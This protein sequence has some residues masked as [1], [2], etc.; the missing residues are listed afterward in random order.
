MCLECCSRR[1]RSGCGWQYPR[2][3]GR[4]GETPSRTSYS[5]SARSIT[6]RSVISPRTTLTFSSSPFRTSSHCGTQSRTRQTT[7]AP[8]SSRLRVS[9][10]PSRPVAP[11]TKTERSRQKLFAI[12]I[13]SR[14]PGPRSR[15]DSDTST[16]GR[17]P[18][19]R[20]SPRVCR[21]S[22]RP[23]APTAREVRVRG[24]NRRRRDSR[25]LFG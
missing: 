14:G 20:R 8:R 16:R 15:A 21:P 2:W 11:V 17:C 19:R 12:T 9:H 25:R 18:W 4:Q 1:W 13:P 3:S 7:L 22:A 24:C 10:P 6:S 5:P 23:H